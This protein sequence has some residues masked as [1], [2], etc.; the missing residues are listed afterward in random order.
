[1]GPAPPRSLLPNFADHKGDRIHLAFSDDL[2]GPWSIHERGTLLLRDTPFLQ[3]P[4]DIPSYVDR[5]ALAMP[6]AED[7]PSVLDDCILP[8]IASPEAI[9]DDA[10]RSIRLYHHGLDA[11]AK[12]VSRVAMSSDGLDFEA[13][14]EILAPPTSA[15]FAIGRV[16]TDSRCLED[17]FE[18]NPGS[19][20]SSRDRCSSNRTGLWLR[21]DELWV[22]WT[23]VGDAPERILLSTIDLALDW[24]TWRAS[25][26]IEV[27]RA[28]E[29]WEGGAL[30]ALPSVRSAI[31]RPANQL[32]DPFLFEDLGRR[33][34]VYALA[35]EA[36]LGI[37]TSEVSR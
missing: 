19:R 6:R 18:V 17:S 9:V 33:F 28:V 4:P 36:G 31:N 37:A 5:E 20:T 21:G 16:G 13:R 27:R 11:F 3:S 35:G 22:F 14:P 7:V 10:S 2:A 1:M 15:Y 34:L 32:R 25:D 8:H 29:E 24:E 23:R 26:P 12:Q 30:P